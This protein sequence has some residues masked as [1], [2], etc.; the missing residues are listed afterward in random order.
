MWGSSYSE[1]ND[2]ANS[3]RKYLYSIFKLE[4]Y[5]GDKAVW[6]LIDKVLMKFKVVSFS[7]KTQ[8]RIKMQQIWNLRD[9][10]DEILAVS[11]CVLTNKHEG[12]MILS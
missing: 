2:F 8:Y 6:C 5:L 1:Y 12:M 9:I 3:Y 10:Y 11:A 4:M 7:N